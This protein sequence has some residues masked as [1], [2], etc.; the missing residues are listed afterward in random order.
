MGDLEAMYSSPQPASHGPNPY[1]SRF[2]PEVF[3]PNLP[4]VHHEREKH[5][6]CLV[7]YF[8]DYRSFSLM[9]LQDAINELWHLEGEV[10]VLKRARPYYIL[11]PSTLSDRDDLLHAGPWN[12]HGAL[13]LLRPWLPDVPLHQ[14]D[15]STADMWVQMSG[16]PLEY[17]TPAM[18]ARLGSLLGMVIAI[19]RDTILQ[20]NMDY[21]HVR[22]QIPIRRPLIPD[23]SSSDNDPTEPSMDEGDDTIS[24][25][26]P[27]MPQEEND[28]DLGESTGE[29]IHGNEIPSPATQQSSSKTY[30]L[31][32][33]FERALNLLG[34]TSGPENV[35]FLYKR[36]ATPLESS[37]LKRSK[38]EFMGQF[39]PGKFFF[40]GGSSG[41][42]GEGAECDN[43][44]G[45]ENDAAAGNPERYVQSSGLNDGSRDESD[46][47]LNILANP[48]NAHSKNGLTF[49]H[50]VNDS[51]LVSGPPNKEI[52]GSPMVEV[53]TCKDAGLRFV[54]RKREASLKD[55]NDDA[56]PS[57]SKRL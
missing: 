52:T 38:V 54:F 50:E 18:A 15:F 41:I 1:H 45:S 22:V 4:L 53:K 6:G 42:H 51:A 43:T 12:I 32:D 46:Q 49:M 5:F 27:A 20:Q 13:F 8:E 17:M 7:G 56:N 25:N 35:S 29:S 48:E 19:D 40:A 36:D 39:G 10:T 30:D 55:S 11:K 31:D 24:L 9:D 47:T 23:P 2:G 44:L 28:H 21:M 3:E 34:L 57:G 33:S 26:E 16:A 37:R 14:L